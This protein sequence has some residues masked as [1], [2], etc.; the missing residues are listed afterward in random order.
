MT[1]HSRDYSVDVTQAENIYEDSE[2]RGVSDSEMVPDDHDE[3]FVENLDPELQEVYNRVVDRVSNERCISREENEA[4]MVVEVT[5]PVGTE[6][7]LGGASGDGVPPAVQSRGDRVDD[8]V[9][10][11]L[12]SDSM[13]PSI[14]NQATKNSRKLYR[15]TH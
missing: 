10:E 14:P 1:Y 7:R 5:V 6:G 2:K 12:I 11:V 9:K 15:T 8:A 13:S 3:S 4:G